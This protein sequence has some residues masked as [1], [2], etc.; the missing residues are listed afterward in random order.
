MKHKRGFLTTACTTLA[1]ASVFTCNVFSADINDFSAAREFQGTATPLI[2]CNLL[3]GFNDNWRGMITY[4]ALP[5]TIFKGPSTDSNGKTTLG[6]VLFTID[7]VG[8]QILLDQY[9]AQ[10][11]IAKENYERDVKLFKTNAIPEQQLATDKAAYYAAIAQVKQQQYLVNLCVIRAP[12]DGIVVSVNNVGWLSGEPPVMQIAQ[13]KPMGIA[14]PMDRSLAN[15]I[16]PSTPITIYPDPSISKDIFGVARGYSILTA[17]GVTFTIANYQVKKEV[18][19]K[20]YPIVTSASPIVPF[21]FADQNKLSLNSTNI[22][23][24][25]KGSFVWLAVGQKDLTTKGI[26]KI[27]SVKK[28]YVEITSESADG[29]IFAK[30]VVLKENKDLA[31]YDMVIGD[32]PEGVKDGD[33]VSFQDPRFVFMPGDNVRVVIGPQPAK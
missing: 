23:K 32:M 4:T 29:A 30:F 19:G 6:T 15:K 18:D 26:D 5:G 11:Q 21:R 17:T 13:L 27:F 9:V 24:D 3:S 7:R 14:V 33:M 2:Q 20:T 31:A 22:F 12:F 10:Y 8:R 28:V 16:T 25:D 1:L